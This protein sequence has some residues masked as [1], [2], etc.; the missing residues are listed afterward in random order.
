MT[1]HD[2]RE[3]PWSVS[4]TWQQE[5]LMRTTRPTV[6]MLLLS[7]I[8]IGLHACGDD[9]DSLPGNPPPS[10]P[11]IVVLPAP[12]QQGQQAPVNTAPKADDKHAL[13]QTPPYPPPCHDKFCEKHSD[14]Y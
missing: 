1:I 10:T 3:K 12:K 11:D 9:A 2:E 7:I 6:M 14:P 13:T 8:S 4:S 5:D